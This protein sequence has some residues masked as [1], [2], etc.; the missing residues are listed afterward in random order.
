MALLMRRTLE[1]GVEW[2]TEIFIVLTRNF[3]Y[4]HFDQMPQMQN[5][6]S[7]MEIVEGYGEY[8]KANKECRWWKPG[9]GCYVEGRRPVSTFFSPIEWTLL[10]VS[11]HIGKCRCLYSC[12]K[13]CIVLSRTVHSRW[14]I[15]VHDRRHKDSRLF[16]IAFH[17]ES[18]PKFL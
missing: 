7:K 10:A 18:L 14:A 2:K 17:S 9:K 4:N 12:E 3:G 1:W 5:I 16:W 13:M 6:C 11:F 8:A 15:H